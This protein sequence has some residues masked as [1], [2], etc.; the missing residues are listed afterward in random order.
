MFDCVLKS[1]P[2]GS[3]LKTY[4]HFILHFYF[5]HGRMNEYEFVNF[6]F[7]NAYQSNALEKANKAKRRALNV[8]N[9]IYFND[10][11]RYDFLTILFGRS[12]LLGCAVSH[13]ARLKQ[14]FSKPAFH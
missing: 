1:F 14:N 13:E 5:Y 9:L 10:S 7:R 3:S 2:A 12:L 8:F 4:H 6:E 11:I